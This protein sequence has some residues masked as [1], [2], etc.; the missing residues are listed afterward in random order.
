MPDAPTDLRNDPLTTSDTVIR[1][2]WSA[3]ISN[4]GT[5][6]LDHTIYYDQGTAGSLILLEVTG[7]SLFYQTTSVTAGKTYRFKVVARNT[8]G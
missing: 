6:V 4:G 2:T 8:V 1:F 5:S 7:T 3:G